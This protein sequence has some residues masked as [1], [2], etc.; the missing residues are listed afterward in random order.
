MSRGS[1]DA[2]GSRVAGEQTRAKVKKKRKVIK[3]NMMK[4]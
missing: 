1:S 4:K 2:C 3:N